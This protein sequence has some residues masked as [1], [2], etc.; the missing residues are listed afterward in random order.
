[1]NRIVQIG[2]FPLSNNS[3]RGGV[4]ASVSGLSLELSKKYE[5]HVFDI[6]RIGVETGIEE[7]GRMVVH[8]FNNKGEYHFTTAISVDK[9]AKDIVALK[10]DIC[11][12]HGTS[13]FSWLIYR[14]LT[15]A[16]FP[17][18]V[19]VHGLV[20]VEKRNALR[21][22]V[23]MKRLIQLLYQGWAERRLLNRLSLVIVDTEYVQDKVNSYL[24]CHRPAIHVIPQGVRE[25]FFSISGSPDS[26]MLLSVGAI[27]ERKGHLITLKAFEQ[28]RKNGINTSLVIAGVVSDQ[29]YLD[30]LRKVIN[31]SEFKK[32]VFL[33]LNVGDD[34]LIELY[35]KARLFVLHSE[36]ESQGI[37]FVEAMAAGL[38][39]VATEVGGVPYVVR[40]Q[41]TGL[42]SRYGCLKDFA[43]NIQRLL[44][45][46]V[47][48][49]KMSLN[50]RSVAQL[51]RWG[52]IVEMVMQCYQSQCCCFKK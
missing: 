11:H 1:M 52:R 43:D 50:S 17:V 9:V 2:P 41:E 30:N 31:D 20:C 16:H 42:L 12:I 37:V 36:E 25:K 29:S 6:P 35:K 45:D 28:V 40:H 47:L 49:E 22:K 44:V 7:R 21:K 24:M 26:R 38:P 33:C 4:E 23:T 34:C 3:G 39:V 27:G 14:K 48:W 5:V 8:R 32:D 15:K 13:L 51:Y 19:T 18:V 10:P 46:D